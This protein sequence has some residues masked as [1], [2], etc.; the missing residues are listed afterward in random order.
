MDAGVAALRESE[1][2]IPILVAGAHAPAADI[3]ERSAADQR[4][5]RDVV[6]IRQQPRVER[7]RHLELGVELPPDLDV[8]PREGRVRS[9][10]QG[11]REALER[12]GNH[13]VVGVER[14]DVRRARDFDACHAR[15][16]KAAVF[17]AGDRDS[18][19]GEPCKC[20]HGGGVIRS[21]VDD[22]ELVGLLI[23]QRGER[24]RKRLAV[25]EARNDDRDAGHS[26]KR[27][28]VDGSSRALGYDPAVEAAVARAR[29]R[30]WVAAD[31]GA[32]VVVGVC[33]LVGGLLRFVTLGRQSFEG[34]EAWT[35]RLLHGSFTHMLRG[36]ARQ[37]STPPLFYVVDWISAHLFGF[38]E[39]AVRAPSAIAG[40]AM[41]ALAYPVAFALLRRRWPAVT[42]AAL[43]AVSPILVW[44]SQEARSYAL[45]A[46]LCAASLLFFARTLDAPTRAN[47]WSWATAS[48]LALGT[49]YFAGFLVGVEAV[50]LLRRHRATVL[51]PIAAVAFVSALLVPL[52]VHQY[53]SAEAFRAVTTG[54]LGWRLKEVGLRF[55]FFN[56]DPGRD[57]ALAIAVAAAALL[58]WRGARR[59][60]GGRIAL[61]IGAVIVAAPFVLASVHV[62]DVFFFR[63]M[64]AAWL[65]LAIAVAAGL[66]G[67]RAAPAL[68]AAAVAV[69][70]L[71]TVQID[72]K[73][74]LQRDSWRDAVSVLKREPTPFV[75]ISNNSLTPPLYWS[76][77]RSLPP[78][79]VD[80]RREYVASPYVTAESPPLGGFEKVGFVEAGNIGILALEAKRPQHLT[81]H[82]LT[83]EGLSAWSVA[84]VRR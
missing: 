79:G 27:S 69:L 51:K 17:T 40:T 44:Y 49:H 64:L 83:A 68:G 56:Y 61:L 33:V 1:P 42:V 11:I 20:R 47:G 54:S 73:V 25:V 65:P 58:A 77:L 31:S 72:R 9:V 66:T 26:R 28:G 12:T 22:D 52:A 45:Y 46:C 71:G 59:P 81:A 70:L 60:G 37:E 43:A 53:H 63:N 82:E 23:L 16:G 21:V 41:V 10:V 36:T 38:G 62:L 55:V 3:L 80:V 15:G 48:A 75:L 8:A 19:V 39:F 30:S 18:L 57:F 76:A 34:D 13:G 50:L 84:P 6:Q 14:E 7:S 74:S 67:L 4:G 5:D 29:A 32:R 2:E 35:L 24:R 78:G